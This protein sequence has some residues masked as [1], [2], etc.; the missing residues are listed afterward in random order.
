MNIIFLT[1]LS[2]NLDRISAAKLR[3][4]SETSKILYVYLEVLIK[5]LPNAFDS[6]A[7][8]LIYV[9]SCNILSLDRTQELNHCITIA[10]RCFVEV[11]G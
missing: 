8:F 5:K 6:L 1:I 9:S 3:Y 2:W 11:H 10:L 4:Y 7:A